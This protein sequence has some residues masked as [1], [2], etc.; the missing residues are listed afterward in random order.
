MKGGMSEQVS[1]PSA[2]RWRLWAICDTAQAATTFQCDM[3]R[4]FGVTGAFGLALSS[5]RIQA[6]SWP[7]GCQSVHSTGLGDPSDAWRVVF[8]VFLGGVLV[9]AGDI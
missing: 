6:L 9:D 8:W 7:V 2:L 4:M 5:E 3:M 1:Q